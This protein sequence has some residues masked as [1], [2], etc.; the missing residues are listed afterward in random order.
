MGKSP[1]LIEKR[2]NPLLPVG[3]L[4]KNLLTIN[5]KSQR[6]LEKWKKTCD[7]AERCIA[8]ET[9]YNKKRYDQIHGEPE[10]Q[11]GYQELVSTLNF[12]S[13]KG[14]KEVIDAF[15]RPFTITRLIRRSSVEAIF[16]EGI[17][18]KNKAFSMSLAKPYHQNGD[19]THQEQEKD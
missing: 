12:N 17:Y 13:L 19:K 2:W 14:P 3:H 6:F 7:T 18:R 15:V 5:P 4:K 9:E 10:F 16:P 8:E 1:F 11:K